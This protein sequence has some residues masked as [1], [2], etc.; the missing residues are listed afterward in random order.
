VGV[1]IDNRVQRA[2]LA[3]SKGFTDLPAFVVHQN[4]YRAKYG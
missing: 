4:H 2:A 1:S 3:A